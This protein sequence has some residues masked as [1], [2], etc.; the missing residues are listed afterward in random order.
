M[1]LHFLVLLLTQLAPIIRL[2]HVVCQMQRLATCNRITLSIKLATRRHSR[3]YRID[4][5]LKVLRKV[6]RLL[7][8]Q[9]SAFKILKAKWVQQPAFPSSL[10]HTVNFT[11]YLKMLL[12][13]FLYIYFA[14]DIFFYV[15][16]VDW[17]LKRPINAQK[18]S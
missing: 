18:T 11:P 12:F 13:T 3:I 15:S 7:F 9:F 10:V 4:S 16:C 14:C 8:S 17:E 5:N 6:K 1:R 2:L